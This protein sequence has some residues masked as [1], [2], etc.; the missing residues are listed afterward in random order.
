[1]VTASRIALLATSCP[2]CGKVRL[3][4][5]DRYLGTVNLYA[6]SWHTHQFIALRPFSRLKGRLTLR[7]ITSGKLVRIDGIAIG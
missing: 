7:V 4:L 1:M 3:Y 6:S 2:T 5:A